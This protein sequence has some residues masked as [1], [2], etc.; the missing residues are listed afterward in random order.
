MAGGWHFFSKAINFIQGFAE[1]GGFLVAGVGLIFAAFEIRKNTNARRVTNR[2]AILE[3]HRELWALETS[4]S[5][6]AKVRDSERDLATS[7]ISEIEVGFISLRILLLSV[8]SDGID[9]GE[10]GVL[11]GL[12]TDVRNFFSRP[13]VKA[14]WKRTKKFHNK[15]LVAFVEHSMVED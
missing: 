1:V 11:D 2:I 12:K 8:V 14:T 13:V 10:L 7:P 6:L 5:E 15:K 3:H 9:K 4:R